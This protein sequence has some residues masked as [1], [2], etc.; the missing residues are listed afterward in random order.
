MRCR[1]Y[2]NL[3]RPFTLFGIQGR[4]IPVAFIALGSALIVSLILGSALGAFVGMAAMLC[5]CIAAYLGILEVQGR[6]G[7]KGLSRF[8]SGRRLP[9]FI[10][11]RSKVWKA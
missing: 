3:D 6:W 7:E 2:R 10:L 4:Y 1:V 8:L 11:I 5:L 9:K